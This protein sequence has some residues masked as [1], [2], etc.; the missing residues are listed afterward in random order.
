MLSAVYRQEPFGFG[1]RM[2][3]VYVGCL[4]A[5]AGFQPVRDPTSKWCACC[6]PRLTAHQA[7]VRHP[8]QV[9]SP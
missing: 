7:A 4:E 2:E 1:T 5:P 9:R 8:C 3:K 6:I